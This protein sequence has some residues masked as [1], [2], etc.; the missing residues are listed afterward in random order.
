M[1]K[2]EKKRA[3]SSEALTPPKAGCLELDYQSTP[4]LTSIF[5]AGKRN[6]NTGS[7]G[8]QAEKTRDRTLARV[9]FSSIDYA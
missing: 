8:C 4:S 5:I 9:A 2:M 6:R 1:S 7:S 3:P